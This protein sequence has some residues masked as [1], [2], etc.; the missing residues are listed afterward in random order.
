M[1]EKTKVELEKKINHCA[2]IYSMYK[3]DPKNKGL[4]LN[5]RTMLTN[6]Y[7]SDAFEYSRWLKAKASNDFTKC[8]IPDTV[9]ESDML[10]TDT[11]MEAI[12]KYDHTKNDNFA[13]YFF[14]YYNY[15]L[16]GYKKTNLKLYEPKVSET[17]HS[18]KD[19]KESASE[20]D[21]YLETGNA[22]D[23]GKNEDLFIIK[24]EYPEKFINLLSMISR[25]SEHYKGK[26]AN[27]KRFYYSTLFTTDR[28]VSFLKEY[29]EISDRIN[30]N[31]F[32]NTISIKF[33]DYF[34][35]DK[36]SDIKAII[37]G[38]LKK[39]NQIA[40]HYKP[41][42]AENEAVQPLRPAVYIKYIFEDSGEKINDSALSQ[43]KKAY[44]TK[45]KMLLKQS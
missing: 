12:K 42:E 10:V 45:L 28:S 32:F 8:Q 14:T 22:Q 38:K 5:H 3:N 31:E 30:E 33:L 4:A 18:D 41:E 23:I 9:A 21:N 27:E 37:S 16:R 26:E 2:T 43:Q 34:M 39:Y 24:V 19:S 36:C 1:D 6:Y 44:E 25:F 15:G 7:L 35:N 29:S 13:A 20:N 11:L 17:E 40:E